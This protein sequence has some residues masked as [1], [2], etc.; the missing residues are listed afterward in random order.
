MVDLPIPGVTPVLTEGPRSSVSGAV[1]DRK[2][3][4]ALVV[5]AFALCGA[6]VAQTSTLPISSLPTAATPLTG[7]EYVPIVQSGATRKAK[8]LDILGGT[9]SGKFNQNLTMSGSATG[10]YAFNSIRIYD[11]AFSDPTNNTFGVLVEMKGRDATANG[12]RFAFGGRCQWDTAGDPASTAGHN[13]CVGVFSQAIANYDNAASPVVAA[14][15]ASNDNAVA[16]ANAKNWNL[17]GGETDVTTNSGSSLLSRVGRAYVLNGDGDQ[18]SVRD[19]GINFLASSSVP[20]AKAW[21]YLIAFDKLSGGQPIATGGTILGVPS[22]PAMTILN[23]IDLSYGLV[24]TGKAFKSP[25][26]SVDGSG[27]ESA[28]SYAT[29]G[30]VSFNATGAP[31]DAHLSWITTNAA[32]GGLRIQALPDAGT[33]AS[34]WVDFTRSGG[35][36]AGVIFSVKTFVPASTT[37][38]AGFNIPPGSLPSGTWQNGDLVTTT[39]NLFVRLNGATK[40]VAFLEDAQTWAL[41]QT[42]SAAIQGGNSTNSVL[43]I[44]SKSGAGATDSINFKTGSQVTRWTIPNAGHL[45]PG[46]ANTYD[47]GTS[48]TTVRALYLADGVYNGST[49][50]IG[51]RVTGWGAPSGTLDRTALAAYAG[52][53][54]SAGYVQAEAQATD[55]ACKKSSQELAAVISDLRTHGLIGN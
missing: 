22:G 48:S 9:L 37:S 36:A 6:A 12:F 2:R 32:T 53:T 20:A 11:G 42:F 47:I 3:I 28:L 30:A 29:T 1:F 41:A 8:L 46:A 55:N 54:V 40:T 23:G 34:S 43:N 39:S 13:G 16:T 50:I 15:W 25:G 27:N 10:E 4:A 31:T 7:S 51:A 33:P 44:Q 49:K 21:K 17:F 5:G 45:T 35:S 38:G 52:Q 24:I 26:W 19:A 18:A 14:M